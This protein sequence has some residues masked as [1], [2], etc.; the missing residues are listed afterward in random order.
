[1]SGMCFRVTIPFVKFPWLPNKIKLFLIVRIECLILED[2]EDQ[3][4]G[5]IREHARF[6]HT[7]FESGPADHY[8]RLGCLHDQSKG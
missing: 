6:A 7:T 8:D 2:C 4:H 1:M 5:S 3:L